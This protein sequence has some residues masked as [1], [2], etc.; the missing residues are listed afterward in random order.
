MIALASFHCSSGISCS[1]SQ[2]CHAAGGYADVG[3][4]SAA[5]CQR[6][7]R[8]EV[9]IDRQP[10]RL[11]VIERALKHRAKMTPP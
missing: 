5:A 6:E 1:A 10:Q 9:G 4:S 7:L 2:A 11:L 3:E 8:E